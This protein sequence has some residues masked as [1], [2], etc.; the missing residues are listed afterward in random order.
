MKPGWGLRGLAAG[1]VALGAALGVHAVSRRRATARARRKGALRFRGLVQNAPDVVVVLRA[2]STVRYVSPSVGRVL[3]YRPEELVG[4][5]LSRYLRPE[6]LRRVLGG[7]KKVSGE[8]VPVP[9]GFEMAHADGSQRYLEIVGVDLLEDPEVG[10]ILCHVRDVTARKVAEVD[11]FRWAFHDALTGLTNRA[12]FMDRLGHALARAPRRPE[13]VAVLFI[14][15]DDFKAVNDGF[16][17]EAGDRLLVEAGRRLRACLRP[18][19]T[20][21]RLGGDEFA[22]LLEDSPGDAARDP[23]RVAD[24]ISEALREPFALSE[25]PMFVTASVG[26]AQ[27]G[28]GLDGAEDLLRAA[29]EAMYRTKR[30]HKARW[31]IPRGTV[32][33]SGHRWRECDLLR[34][35]EHEELEVYYQPEVLP[36]RGIA[37]ME[38]LLRWEHPERGLVTMAEFITVAEESGLIVPVGRWVL[39]EACRQ[40][41]LWRERYP[42]APPSISV[43][44]SAGQL[45]GAAPTVAAVLRETGLDPS[46][47]TLEFREG[48]L[49]GDEGEVVEELLK[50]KGL[51]VG[52]AIDHFGPAYPFL[53]DL[54]RVPVDF[55]KIDRS[56]VRKLGRGDRDARLLV[57]L[58][59]GVAQATGAR[60]VAEG[61][62]T[63][64]QLAELREME[65]DLAQGYYFWE[66]LPV[67]DAT[68]ILD[69]D[70]ERIVAGD[71]NGFRSG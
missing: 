50:L 53:P 46:A 9:V 11:L 59:V 17:H 22:V 44:L 66:P 37:G 68:E 26:V 42:S 31:R 41:L 4:T 10:G 65:C 1:A 3:G 51:G 48:V 61:V 63:A 28:A 30:R 21:A 14:D 6:D 35:V 18:G 12:L 69:S 2:D 8:D 57:S 20:V 55:L 40:A 16:G 5:R 70:F 15:L 54:A 36:G 58:Y 56:L 29:D 39:R 67:R 62:E 13:P 45:R 25:G 64:E 7:I 52:L 33:G 23:E 71:E 47:L 24:R 27:S 49:L 19:D 43:N 60:A 38:A 32:D 34:A